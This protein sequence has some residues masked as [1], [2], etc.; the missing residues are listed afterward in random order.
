M[1]SPTT[2][3]G[4]TDAEILHQVTLS[5]YWIGK[6]EVTTTLWSTRQHDPGTVPPDARMPQTGMTWR[7]AVEFCNAYSQQQGRTQVYENINDNGATVNWNAN[8]YRLP[9]EAEWEFACRAETVEAF[10]TGRNKIKPAEANYDST[11]NDNSVGQPYDDPCS[12]GKDT[13]RAI[14]A[15][16]VGSFPRNPWGLYDMHGNVYEWCWDRYSAT[17]YTTADARNNPRGPNDGNNRVIRGGAYNSVAT[18]ARSAHR[19]S[20]P[21]TNNS[22]SVNIGFRLVRLD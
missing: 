6:N 12:D 16:N 14:Q 2:E 1:G 15:R 20:F 3:P 19:L 18:D 13:N 8:G 11:G 7:Q 10:N 9:T 22:T 21:A 5:G 4:H 17:Y